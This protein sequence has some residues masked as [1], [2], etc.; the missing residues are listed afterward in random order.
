MRILAIDPGSKESGYCCYDTKSSELLKGKVDNHALLDAVEYNTPRADVLVIEQ[1]K[2]YGMPTGDSIHN[3][4]IWIGQFKHAWQSIKYAGKTVYGRKIVLI[5]RKTVC[6]YICNSARAKD[7]NIRAALLD[8][9]PATGG[10]KTPQVGI[11]S[12]PGPLFGFAADMWS[13][14]ALAITYAEGGEIT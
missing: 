14:L 7:S 1:I 10:G 13:A 5:P 6:G 8:R 9:F 2:S 4:N 12:K 11:K 3:T